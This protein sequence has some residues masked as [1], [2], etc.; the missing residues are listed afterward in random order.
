MKPAILS[1]SLSLLHSG[2]YQ[3]YAQ[4]RRRCE[5][6]PANPTPVYFL[7]PLTPWFRAAVSVPA[8][9]MAPPG[10]VHSP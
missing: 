2:N 6:T 8:Q 1:Q 9:R 10:K 5:A 3:K 7:L 4:V